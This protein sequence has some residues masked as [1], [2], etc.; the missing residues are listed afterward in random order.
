MKRT[1]LA[2]ALF[3]AFAAPAMAQISDNVVRI[4]VLT[5]LSGTYSDLTGA[6]AV[7]ATE[8]AVADFIAKEKPGFKIET[9][10][11]TRR[12]SGSRAARS[13][14]PP[15]SSPPRWHWR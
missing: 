12:A 13:T 4:G 3:T 1:A 14:P 5:D 7:Y 9:S 8:M 15:N 2:A 10:P 6:G 11:P